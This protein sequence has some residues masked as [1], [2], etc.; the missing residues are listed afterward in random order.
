MIK[1]CDAIM[2][3]GK[4]SAAI[5]YMN[6]HPD[7]RYVYITPY[8]EEATRIRNACPALD[9]QEPRKNE[10][11]YGY[12]KTGHTRLLLEEG[13]NITTTHQ[14][15]M[16]YTPE[17]LA[18][19]K[20]QG[21][22]LLIDE[23]VSVL[24]ELEA[25][26]GD[27]ESLVLAG[28]LTM[29]EAGRY[30][31]GDVEYKGKAM[32]ETFRLLVSRDLM[33][34]TLDKDEDVYYWVLPPDLLNSFRDVFI[35]TYLF[36][37]QDL[38]H[39]L[40]LYGFDYQHIGVSRDADG[41][42][43]FCDHAGYIPDYVG[44]LRDH[45]HILDHKKLNAI[46]DNYYA[47]SHNWYRSKGLKETLKHHIDNYFRNITKDHGVK[48]RLWSTFKDCKMALR[49][50]GYTNNHLTFNKKATNDF[51]DRTVLVYAV[52]IF[53]PVGQKLFFKRFGV[54]VDE[55]M[56]ALSAMVQWIWRS[57]IR[58]GK[59]IDIYIPSRRMRELLIKWIATEEA[60]YAEYK[61]NMLSKEAN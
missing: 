35:L 25:D 24:K 7:Q 56:Y 37:G 58:D 46:G 12:T 34:V 15:F 61:A 36:E 21:Y 30:S 33:R 16:Y 22:V 38:H 18:L 10:G 17:V 41:T 55:E 14:A 27:I 57:A 28:Q 53:M 26:A 29:D 1:V 45:I 23:D 11:T 5:T 47:L 49:G 9:F 2:G 32:H 4:S 13:R 20:D 54:N 52:N 3:S 19:I 50:K 42:Y 51:R 8:L 44:T 43:R 48:E 60:R 39:F 6:E 40:K 59:P 31:I